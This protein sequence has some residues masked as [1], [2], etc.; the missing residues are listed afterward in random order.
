MR[1]PRALRTRGLAITVAAVTALA[2]A[3]C[4]AGGGTTG[5]ST[6]GASK[7]PYRVLVLGGLSA[8]GALA[9]NASTSVL[10]AQAG[11]AT[12]NKE[13]GINGR[14]IKVTVVDD[15]S[16]PTTAVTAVR[17]AINSSTPPDLVLNSGPST[18]ADATLPIISQAG[19][20]SFNIGPT[21]TSSDPKTFPLNFDLSAGPTE[22]LKGFIGELKDKKYKKVGILH[23]S[24]AYG[25]SFGKLAETNLTAA[26][27]KV[28]T[29]QE[30]DVAAL[31]MTPQIQAI[32]A[33]KP[34]ALILDAYG[35]PLGY[36][37]Q[38]I[39]KLGWDIPIV[40]DNS[41]AATSLTSTPPPAGVLGTDQVKNLTMEVYAS[42]KYNASAT[43]TNEAVK[44]MKSLGTIKATLILAYNY[45]APILVAAA[46][47]K[48][49]S[50]DPKAI[51]KALEDSAV[52][53]AAKTAIIP[54]YNFNS[55]VHS[56]NLTAA[57]FAFI[58]PAKIVDGQFH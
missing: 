30:Y 57:A 47:K 7:E 12:V 18:V 6:S 33:T 1:T 16:D 25:E 27:V 31:D 3:S 42:T 34:D 14:K 2:L 35:A 46:A 55:T 19:I 45:D 4:S 52:T 38:G 23:G 51:A 13:G 36:V 44:E 8:A 15:K 26:G 20:L 29:N 49:K 54:D 48:A 39:Q 22:Y 53:K 50:T 41:V 11:A 32:Q 9:D 10:S 56:P 58:A 24:S 28:T 5:G 43:L 40:A 17:E 21:A 37:L